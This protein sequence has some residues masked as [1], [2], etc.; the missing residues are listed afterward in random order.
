V[1]AVYNL[2]HVVLY[3]TIDKFWKLQN[4]Q[5]LFLRFEPWDTGNAMNYFFFF[6]SS[7]FS[8]SFSFSFPQEW[9]FRRK[10]QAPSAAAFGFQIK[11][12]SQL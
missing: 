8:S 3:V 5:K 12:F 6:F 7:S 1:S 11:P 9:T 2:Q 4:I 10:S